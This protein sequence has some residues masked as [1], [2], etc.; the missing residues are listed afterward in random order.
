MN[1]SLFI[2]FRL[3]EWMLLPWP[4]VPAHPC[5]PCGDIFVF[6][7]CEMRAVCALHGAPSAI[8]PGRG[9][10]KCH[11]MDQIPLLR[12][13]RKTNSV[14]CQLGR[15]YEQNLKASSMRFP[16]TLIKLTPNHQKSHEIS[17]A[18]DLVATELQLAGEVTRARANLVAMGTFKCCVF[19][20]TREG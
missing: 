18:L 16:T 9:S 7:W 11:K 5:L 1:H 8:P 6:L 15:A 10:W 3:H 4:H 17:A 12:Y 20:P 19:A 14:P 2:S 13:R